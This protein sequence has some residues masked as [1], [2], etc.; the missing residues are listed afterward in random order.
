MSDE[1]NSGG[2]NGGEGG[3]DTTKVIPIGRGKKPS[4]SPSAKKKREKPK[5]GVELYARLMELTEVMAASHALLID[6]MQRQ[7]DFVL[8]HVNDKKALEEY[9][10]LVVPR[11]FTIKERVDE[12]REILNSLE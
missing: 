4:A 5:N 12:M 6:L 11:M 8:A 7:Q 1:K 9:S 2:K 3:D 10:G